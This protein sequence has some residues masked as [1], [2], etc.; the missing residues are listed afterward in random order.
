MTYGA[1]LIMDNTRDILTDEYCYVTLRN[2]MYNW[3]STNS[4]LKVGDML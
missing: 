4:V 1:R 3:P 2:L